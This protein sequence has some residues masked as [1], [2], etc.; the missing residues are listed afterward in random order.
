MAQTPQHRGLRVSYF[1]FGRLRCA[2]GQWRA[3][4]EGLRDSAN[5]CGLAIRIGSAEIG[6]PVIEE[7]L[8]GAPA[9][10]GLE[11]ML[12]ANQV[13]DTSDALVSPF[14]VAIDRIV[15]NLAVLGRWLATVSAPAPVNRLELWMTEGYETL[16]EEAEVSPS[17]F[18]DFVGRRL[19][20]DGDVPS[21]RLMIK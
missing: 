2:R 16:F 12:M 19:V 13:D 8:R 14:V 7:M 1:V 18:A 4:E 17:E 21:L 15:E 5:A 11:Y 10:E 6:Q 20:A 9:E 3:V